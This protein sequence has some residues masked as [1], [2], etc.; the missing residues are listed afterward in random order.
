MRI[1]VDAMGGDH[2]PGEIVAGALEGLS[3]LGS[4]D[5][6]VLIGRREV[7]EP[8]LPGGSAAGQPTSDGPRVIVHHAPDVIGMDESPV[9]ALRQKKQSSIAVMA[10]L[11]AGHEVDAVISAGNTGACAAACQL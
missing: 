3:F 4:T 7:I 8:L 5:E 2:A 1:A 10:R 9:E 11:A 6:L